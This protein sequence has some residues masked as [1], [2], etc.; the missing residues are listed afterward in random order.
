MS[1][2]NPGEDL[3]KV[4]LYLDKDDLEWYKTI[5]QA[6]IGLS[7][8]VRTVMR[9]YRNAIEAQSGQAARRVEAP[10]AIMEEIMEMAERD[11]GK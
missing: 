2:D 6:K 1:R 3:C 7:K 9:S 5:F 8:S 10:P 11:Q 4:H